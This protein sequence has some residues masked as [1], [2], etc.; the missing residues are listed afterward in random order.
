MQQT[1][2]CAFCA[3]C[4]S[5]YKG[6]PWKCCHIAW[7]VL[8]RA[9]PRP[10][11]THC[12]C[13]TH[14]WSFSRPEHSAI[15]FFQHHFSHHWG[16]I[17]PLLKAFWTWPRLF[18]HFRTHNQFRAGEALDHVLP[19]PWCQKTQKRVALEGLVFPIGR[20]RRKTSSRMPGRLSE[21]LTLGDF[22][23]TNPAIFPASFFRIFFTYIVSCWYFSG[24]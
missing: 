1:A 20:C 7:A 4:F 11:C 10:M 12:S 2:G 5:A 14:L 6:G 24:F 19:H 23:T 9:S 22:K 18:L 21:G 3:P 8:T 16:S 13:P 15:V 17:G